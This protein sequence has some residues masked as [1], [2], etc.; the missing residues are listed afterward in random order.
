MPGRTKRPA[1]STERV[2]TEAAAVADDVG[3]DNLTFAAVAARLGISVPGLY[4]H[5]ASIDAVRREIA[6]LGIEDLTDRITMATIGKS[7]VKA[8]RAAAVAYRE[9]ACQHPGRYAASIVA[10]T[11]GDER[12]NAASDRLLRIMFAI[13]DGFNF[14]EAEAIDAI[15]SFRAIAHGFASLEAADGFGIP[16]SVDASFDRLIT[17]YIAG[18]ES[19][20][21][22]DQ[23][24]RPLDAKASS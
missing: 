14:S 12:H 15:R 2:I 18:L 8:I 13:L 5:V 17:M 19:W 20:R 23:G 21:S 3:L 4:K 11:P 9:Y 10:P 16:Q 24:E 1:V 7:D 6:I 22:P